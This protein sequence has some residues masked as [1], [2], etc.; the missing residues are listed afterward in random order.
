MRTIRQT[1]SVLNTSACTDPVGI[2]TPL[3]GL[4]RYAV[5]RALSF[6]VIEQYYSPVNDLARFIYTSTYVIDDPEVI[7]ISIS[8]N[9]WLSRNQN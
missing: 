6:V 8:V 4:L 3:S 7:Y 5:R 2:R 1:M 9:E